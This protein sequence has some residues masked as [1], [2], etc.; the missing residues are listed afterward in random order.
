MSQDATKLEIIDFWAVWCG[1]CKFMEPIIDEL[2]KKYH[3]RVTFTKINVDENQALSQQ[4]HVLSIPTYL[5][6]IGDTVV[7][8]TIG[9]TSKEQFEKKIIDHLT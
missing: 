9:S 6:K 5:F 3:D 1:P 7:D 8:Q 4:Y 2:E